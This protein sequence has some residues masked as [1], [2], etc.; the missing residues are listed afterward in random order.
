M[1][2]LDQLTQQLDGDAIRQISQQV[3]A[4]E[5]AVSKA[6]SGGLPLLVSALARN[7]SDQGGASALLGALDRDHDGSVL[8][9]V[10]GFLGGGGASSAGAPILKHV[11]GGNRQAGAETAIGKMSGLDGQKVSQILAMLAPMVLGALGRQRRQQG[12]DAGGL[13]DLLGSEH[14]RAEKKAPEA[15]G[16]VGQLLDSDGDGQVADDLARLGTGL[17]GKF[18]GGR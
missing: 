18:L 9:D 8:D 6:V 1:S 3:G 11:L 10:M 12:L 16:L 14:R 2:L 17:L 13:A 5:G 4:D 7:S 15:M